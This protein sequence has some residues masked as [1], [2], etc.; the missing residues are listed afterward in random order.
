MTK[1]PLTLGTDTLREAAAGIGHPLAP[2]RFVF[3]FSDTGGGHRA[4]AQAV[5]GEM[6]RLYGAAATV[7]LL[8]VFAALGQWPFDRFPEWYPTCVGLN[9]IPWGV[10][11][12]LSDGA[13][14]VK[15]MSRIVWPYTRSALCSL[16]HRHPADVI[17]SFHPVPN[18]ALSM[19]LRHM[20]LQ[21]PFAIVAVDLVTTHAAWFVPGAD[22]YFVPTL[23]AEARAKR[24][25][26]APDHIHVTGMPA[27][28]AFVEAIDLSQ[29][30]AR[31]QLGLPQDRPV[32]L[33]VGGGDGMGP[34]GHVVRALARQSASM[35][36]VVVTGRNRALQ[37]EL[38]RLE[39]PAPVPFRATV[40]IEGFV[41]NMEAW[42]RAADV[43]VTKA[44]PNTLAEAFVAGLPLVL[45]AALP[46][47]EEGNI[48][49]VVQNGAGLWAPF[50][51]Q[52]ARAVVHLVEHPEERHAMAARSRALARPL[53]T[54]QIA[55][56]VWSL[57]AP[58]SQ[59]IAGDAHASRTHRTLR[60]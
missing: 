30:E 49:H 12:H 25:G 26:I 28:R 53:A 39:L 54:E 52:A 56:G 23:A 58:R 37:Q 10:G 5:K 11:F 4:S 1:H 16:L 60:P 15:T 42:M 8:D 43:L 17:V 32:V 7:E 48:D 33:V 44:G 18:Y 46:G 20:G 9:G 50:P 36:V 55:R 22:L 45:F 47:Q 59:A 3:L 40:Q 2:K 35:H 27:R 51:R 24:W 6:E 31:A 14:L 38:A 19:S 34:L 57:A 29:S 41:S 13:R 21:V